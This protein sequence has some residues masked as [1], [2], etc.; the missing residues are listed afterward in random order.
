M[1]ILQLIDSL[2]TGGAERMCVNIANVLHENG[3]DVVVCATRTG[4][5]LEKHLNR[6]IEYYILDKKG[7]INI[8]AFRKLMKIIRANG[9]DVIH[10]HSSSLFWAVAAK[11]FI[12]DLKII[13]H[14]HLGLKVNERETKSLYRLFSG[15]I[16]AIIAVNSDLAEWSVKNM[17]VL[18]DRVFTLNNFPFLEER[19]GNKNPDYFTIVCLA[20]IR[21]QKDHATLI[22]AI[23]TLA[24]RELPKK[25]RVI[26]AGS[27]TEDEYFNGLRSLV[28]NL[29]L[30]EIIEF[31]GSVE[32]TASL[33]A[34]A[35]CG[36]LS[37]VSEGLPV[38]LLEYGMA[39]LP[40]VVTD[41]GQ[42]PE[43]VGFGKYGK[44][45]TPANSDELADALYDLLIDIDNAKEKARCLKE[46]IKISYSENRFLR[47]YSVIMNI[48]FQN[49]QII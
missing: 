26:L 24:G 25:L 32:D 2:Q 16:D 47:E 31:R 10:S 9:I 8:V 33:L 29:G 21:P 38:S 49:K 39:G 7:S 18:P 14:D 19:P 44:L 34:S 1:R 15:Q 4:G 48:L 13:W 17:K 20:N 22:K 30:G 27:Y 45:I 35:D 36:V 12:S 6:G 43:I 40:V 42:C 3:Y 41:V 5:P 23:G 28:D 46:N 37:S 11:F